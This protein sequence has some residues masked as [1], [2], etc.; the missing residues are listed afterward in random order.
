MKVLSSFLFCNLFVRLLYFGASNTTLIKSMDASQYSVGSL[1][2]TAPTYLAV[3]TSPSMFEVI[4]QEASFFS[5]IWSAMVRKFFGRA[6]A[7]EV[8]EGR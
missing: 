5:A 6:V 8:V 3:S 7:V 1:S 4:G 2:T